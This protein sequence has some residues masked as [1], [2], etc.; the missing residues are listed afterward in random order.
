M[1]SITN[2]NNKKRAATN[3]SRPC[4][5]LLQAHIRIQLFKFRVDT[6]TRGIKKPTKNKAIFM[7]QISNN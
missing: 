6:S 5:S 2:T 3:L 4:I 1:T 7:T